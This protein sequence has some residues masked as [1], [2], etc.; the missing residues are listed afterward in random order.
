VN[1][2]ADAASRLS[3]QDMLQGMTVL[4]AA[5]CLVLALRWP[6]GGV[7]V[8]D[9]WFVLASVRC[10][11]LA[12]GALA[13][14]T[15]LGSRQRRSDM[16]EAY[17]PSPLS[18]P[19]GEPAWHREVAT[20]LLAVVALVVVTAPFDV[21]AHAATYPGTSLAWSLVA[22]LLAAT[23]FFGLGLALGRLTRVAHLVALLPLLVPAVLA[24]AVWL[25]LSLGVRLVNPWFA[26]VQP[27]PWF[28]VLMSA[29]TVIAV[30]AAISP[31]RRAP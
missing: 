9:S 20:T 21:L 10:V 30:V 15:A 17:V 22:P 24:G 23:G 11:L 16:G 13:W 6:S 12:F 28:A 3:R 2:L 29:L 25:D 1:L 27:S 19:Y 7:L 18:P 4:L 26:A 31:R 5:M 14:G 8:N